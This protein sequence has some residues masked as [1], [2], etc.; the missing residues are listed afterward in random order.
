M[1]RAGYIARKTR[2][3]GDAGA[4]GIFIKGDVSVIIQ[5]KLTG[6]PQRKASKEAVEDLIRAQKAYR[7]PAGTANLKLVALTNAA[8]FNETAK[9]LARRYGV[10]LVA[11]ENLLDWVNYC[12]L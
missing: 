11:R 1:R 9:Q 4:D 5:C 12:G 8:Q 6:N 10:I 2:V 3:V 7:L